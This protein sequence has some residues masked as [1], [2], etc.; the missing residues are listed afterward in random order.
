MTIA[1]RRAGAA[2]CA[3]AAT[4]ALAVAAGC[5]GDDEALSRAEF[6]A[7][8]SEICAAGNSRIAVA[9]PIGTG[10]GPPSGAAGREFFDTIIRETRRQIDEIAALKPPDELQAGVDDLEASARAITA[11]VEDQGPEAYFASQENPWAEVA[12]KAGAL[13]VSGCAG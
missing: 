3:A 11:E 1:R 12:A 7:Q 4:L 5:G 2:A 10:D 9:V 13:G 6:I 8:A